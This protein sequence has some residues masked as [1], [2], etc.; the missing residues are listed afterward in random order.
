MRPAAMGKIMR[1][2]GLPPLRLLDFPLG[3][4]RDVQF[5]RRMGVVEQE[6]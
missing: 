6:S 5:G 4:R 3:I 2:G 1:S